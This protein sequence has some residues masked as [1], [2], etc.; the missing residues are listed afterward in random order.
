MRAAPKDKKP[1]EFLIAV[2]SVLPVFGIDEALQR[3]SHDPAVTSGFFIRFNSPAGNPRPDSFA[4]SRETA[5][6]DMIINLFQA[7]QRGTSPPLQAEPD[8]KAF[9]EWQFSFR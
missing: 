9:R 1:N 5:F 3:R 2:R 7:G 4:N 6:L 8:L